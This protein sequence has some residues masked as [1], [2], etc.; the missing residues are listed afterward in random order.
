MLVGSEREMRLRPSGREEN[1]SRKE[2]DHK[3]E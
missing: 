3:E 2:K 1:L